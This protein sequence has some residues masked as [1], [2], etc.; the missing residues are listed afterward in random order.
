MVIR[1]QAPVSVDIID[2]AV[3]GKR[4][5][6]RP[7]MGTMGEM[8][9]DLPRRARER[10]VQY[11]VPSRTLLIRYADFRVQCPVKQQGRVM[12]DAKPW[13][14]GVKGLG[15]GIVDHDGVMSLNMP[16]HESDRRRW[17]VLYVVNTTIFAALHRVLIWAWTILR[18]SCIRNDYGTQI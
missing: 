3:T 12:L 2:G 4:L 17:I 11:Y 14:N 5:F 9:K 8:P 1:C 13:F 6:D 15:H 16:K 7:S 18:L 10:A